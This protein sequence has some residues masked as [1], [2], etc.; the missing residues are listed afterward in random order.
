MTGSGMA[1]PRAKSIAV[2]AASVALTALSTFLMTREAQLAQAAG[3]ALLFLV[4]GVAVTVLNPRVIYASM[5]FALGAIPFGVL[6]GAGQPI[7]FLLAVAVWGA[8]LTHP[9]AQ[10]R[11]S[12]LEFTV[13][14]LVVASLISVV[15]TADGAAHLIEFAKWLLATSLVFALLRLDYRDLRLFG[16]AFVHGVGAAAAFALG[17]F[18]LDKAGTTLNHLAIIGY[19]RTGTIGT[20][21]RFYVMDNSTVVRLTGTYVDPNAAG[22]FL[23]VGLALAVAMLRGWHRLVLGGV[24]VSALIITLSRSAIFTVVV[25]FV[26]LLLFQKMSLDKKAAALAASIVTAAGLM[27]VPAVYSR[28]FDSFSSSDKGT[29]D[30]ADALANYGDAMT[31][32]WWFGRGWGIPEFTDEVV[33]YQTNYVANSPLLA[34]YRGGLFVGA[35]FLAVLVVGAV[36]AYR[37]SRCEPWENGVIGAAFVGFALVGLQLDFPV[38]THAP[39]TMVFSVFIVFLIANPIDPVPPSPER[40]DPTI[41]N[42]E[43]A[44]HG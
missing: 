43:V 4:V 11:T 29:A 3:F 16:V 28:I 36:L 21:L 24:I 22:I 23:L 9:I 33:G 10:T 32:H 38:V 17:V 12:P 8:V 7:I 27:T 41:P 18:F 26:L 40:L 19:G 35:A 30:R 37:R 44:V 15:V 6:P 42:P 20:H 14:A 5:A 34:I 13:F 25:A 2:T 39:L 1:H 31:G